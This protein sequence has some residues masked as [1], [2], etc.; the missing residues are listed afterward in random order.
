MPTIE[1][2]AE[3]EVF[4]AIFVTCLNL[5]YDTYDYLPAKD[6]K[7]PFVFVGE[8]FQQDRHTKSG[9]FGDI[10]ATVHI[11][12]DRKKRRETTTM[13]DTIKH[14]LY[15]VKRAG[16]IYLRLKRGTGQILIDNST[17]EPLLHGILELEFTFN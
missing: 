7:Y 16:N 9:L 13:R 4:D 1:K 12:N 11:Y 5:G 3:Q 2:S 6:A 15:K 8:I 17:P 10:Q 14:E